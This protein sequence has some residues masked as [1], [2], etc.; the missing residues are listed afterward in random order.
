MIDF[1]VKGLQVQV[2]PFNIKIYDSWKIKKKKEMKEC[3]IEILYKA[4][5]YNTRRSVN[6]MVREWRTHNI[7][8]NHG[9]LLSH[10]KD[11][12]LESNEKLYRRFFYNIFG[13]F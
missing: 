1:E 6:S 11:C 13:R 10:T 7:F 4:P 2:S 8:Y 3:I 12:D 5:I 9:W